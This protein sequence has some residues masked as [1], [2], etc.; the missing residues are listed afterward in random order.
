VN[1]RAF[2]GAAVAAAS[3]GVVGLTS[4]GKDDAKPLVRLATTTSVRDTGLLDRLLPA[5]T[6]ETGVEVQAVA[7]GTGEALKYGE[8]G[9]ADV[10]LVHSRKAED[11]FVAKGYGVERRDAWWNRFLFLAP[12]SESAPAGA[13]VSPTEFLHGIRTRGATFVSR[14]DDSG[15]HKREKELWGRDFSK[16]PGYLETGQGMGPTLTVADEKDAYVLTDEGTWLR[17]R[18]NLRLRPAEGVKDD[19]T[20]KNPY[21]V[22]LVDPKRAPKGPHEAARRLFEWLTSEKARATVKGFTIDGRRLFY[23]PGEEAT[24]PNH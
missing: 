22:I 8:H 7:V 12:S 2:L 15:T 3:L 23:L 11:E 17:M 18:S 14:G 24:P 9:D 13:P 20:L 5:F 21:G 6:A 19:G 4:C 10:V 16:W 1:R